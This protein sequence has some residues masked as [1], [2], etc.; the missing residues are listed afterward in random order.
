MNTILAQISTKSLK[1][2]FQGPVIIVPTKYYKTP[3]QHFR[4]LGV[5]MVIWANHNLRSSITA[6]Q[7]TTATI[8]KEQSL[9]SIE[10]NVSFKTPAWPLIRQILSAVLSVASCRELH[11]LCCL[12]TGRHGQ[13][14]VPAP[15]RWRAGQ[16]RGQILTQK[17]VIHP[18]VQQDWA[19]RNDRPPYLP[20]CPKQRQQGWAG[21]NI[22]YNTSCNDLY[23]P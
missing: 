15:E 11:D 6:M 22:T 20:I 1:P 21:P 12:F 2:E 7:R 17:L 14:S 18:R 23:W 8:Y 3:T 13:R 10:Q 16:C 9:T 5:S 4:D 19:A